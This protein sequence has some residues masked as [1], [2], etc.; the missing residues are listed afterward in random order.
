[1][2]ARAD[3]GRMK[4]LL[5]VAAYVLA[6]RGPMEPSALIAESLRLARVQ[7]LPEELKTPASRVARMKWSLEAL[8]FA[9]LASALAG[10][11]ALAVVEY[12]S[13]GLRAKRQPDWL[14]RAGWLNAAYKALLPSGEYVRFTEIFE[15]ATRTANFRYNLGNPQYQLYVNLQGTAEGKKLFSQR[16]IFKIGL[17]AKA[18]VRIGRRHGLGEQQ[19]SGV[20]QTIHEANLE[21]LIAENLECVEQGLTLVG[22]QYVT[23]VGRIDLLCRDRRGT[24]VVIELK[25]FGAST[26]YVIGQITRYM[27]W[28]KKHLAGK[29][30]DVRG[31][32]VVA[33]ADENLAYAVSA[34]PN[35]EVKTFNLTLASYSGI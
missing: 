1:M 23:P 2:R 31:I 14:P 30:Q 3:F 34:I 8:S 16:G 24:L 13:F 18:R 11:G 21:G 22:R 32:I 9:V 10:D 7:V 33:K 17:Q 28:V 35:L 25:K 15:K 19:P 12:P 4:S 6:E 29:G 20:V 5:A 26:E 27:G